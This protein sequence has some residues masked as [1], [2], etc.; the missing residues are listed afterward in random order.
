M[1]YIR[2]K[3]GYIFNLAEAAPNIKDPKKSKDLRIHLES[4]GFGEIVKESDLIEELCDGLIV[5]ENGN[6]S[7]W[8]FMSIDDFQLLSYDDR[9]YRWNGWTF[10]AFT[11]TDKGFV[12]VAEMNNNGV[13]ELL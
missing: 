8:F 5:E 4:Y 7:N 10:K 3:N 1:K 2:T 6:E 12:F 13:L 9:Q 11:K